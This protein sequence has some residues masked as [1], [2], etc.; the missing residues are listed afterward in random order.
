MLNEKLALGGLT[1]KTLTQQMGVMLTT[2]KTDLEK[3]ARTCTQQMTP[4]A[5][6]CW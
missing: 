4:C 1:I 3:E 6:A 2:M 5:I